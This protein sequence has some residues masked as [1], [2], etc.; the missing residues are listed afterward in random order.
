MSEAEAS[1][2]QRLDVWLWRARLFK[3]RSE[4]ARCIA[5][6]GVRLSREGRVGA[7]SKAAALI[8][9]GDA[10]TVAVHGRVRSLEILAVGSRRG[11]ASEARTLYRDLAEENHDAV[12]LDAEGPRASS[13]AEQ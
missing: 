3:T 9:P 2:R 10:L 6:G 4:A 11:P 8:G 13:S 7:I 1:V 5:A 12:A